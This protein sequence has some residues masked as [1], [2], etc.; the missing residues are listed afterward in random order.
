[1]TAVADPELAYW[2]ALI[3]RL[4]W[5]GF[6]LDHEFRLVW[7]SGDLERFLDSPPKEELGYGL[8]IFEAFNRDAWR[9][10]ATPES[11]ARL[12]KDL[13]PVVMGDASVQRL[14]VDAVSDGVRSLLEEAEP[15]PFTRPIATSLDYVEPRGDG[16]LPVMRVN[17]L[18]MPL[19]DASGAFVGVLVLGYMSV[20]PGLVSLLARGDE[21]MYERMASLVEPQS[22][23]GGILFCD[24]QGSTNLARTLPTSE[25]FRLIRSL[26]TEIDALVAD[27]EGVIGKHA[28]D[29]ASAFFLVGN[30]G[31]P[32]QAAAA[33]IR[34]AR[35]IHDRSD[36]IFGTIVAGSCL[37]RVG[38]HWGASLYIGQ[39]V[40]GGRLDIAALG[41]A[42]NECARIQDCADPH[43]TLASKQL[44]E[45]LVPDDAAGLGIDADKIRYRPLAEI[46]GAS[47][48]A[49]TVAGAIPVAAL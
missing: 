38:V 48:K 45:H 4:R 10:I 22:H 6:L 34:T 44:I 27:N 12:V 3:E 17:V 24:L 43:E 46:Q 5:A 28:G 21:S 40:P 37:M 35:A 31:S 49:I 15:R 11:R 29:G 33:A 16:E 39:L 23:E 1:M 18:A 32:P 30:L 36:D 8:H 26:W 9:R 7:A 25:Y 2:A 19:R 14:K 47:D 42:V 41:D 20:R 13:A